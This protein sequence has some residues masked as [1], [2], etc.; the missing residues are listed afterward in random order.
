MLIKI[1]VLDKGV[2]PLDLAIF[3]NVG[4]GLVSLLIVLI[5]GGS[6][7]VPQESRQ[8]L[9]IRNIL[10]VS[11]NTAVTYGVT[12]V[13]LVLQQTISSSIPFWAALFGFKFLRESLSGFTLLA[14]VASFVA[15]VI[16]SLEE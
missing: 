5:Q 2:A 9:F 12:L 7:R 3:R 6:L 14:M 15:I 16:I 13:P 4:S 1:T 10:G 11:G 8:M